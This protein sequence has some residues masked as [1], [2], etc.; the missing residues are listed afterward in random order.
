N[1]PV[2]NS[3]AITLGMLDKAF[4]AGNEVT[5]ETLKQKSLI[6][7]V[8]ARAR[9]A[10]IV[11]TGTLSKKLSIVGVPASSGAKEAIEKAGGSLK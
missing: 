3:V 11:A 1:L 4:E 6:T 7:A 10:K 9:S 2:K 8:E 5:M